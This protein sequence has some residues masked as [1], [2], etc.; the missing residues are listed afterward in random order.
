MKERKDEPRNAFSLLGTIDTCLDT[1]ILRE[2]VDS[3]AFCKATAQLI[4][5][6]H[7]PSLY[8]PL[9][10]QKKTSGT[11]VNKF[12][13]YISH[14]SNTSTI[15]LASP[16]PPYPVP[17]ISSLNNYFFHSSHVNS[18]APSLVLSCDE[19]KFWVEGKVVASWVGRER[20]ERKRIEVEFTSV[21]FTQKASIRSTSFI[22]RHDQLA[23]HIQSKFGQRNRT[24]KTKSKDKEET[25]PNTEF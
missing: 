24:T 11:I 7:I 21:I 9:F 14:H 23:L 18:F 6:C 10:C 2:L 8:D 19:V 13:S 4:F 17:R 5:D 16:F 12:F 20:N 1:N 25:F 15:P 22:W 3:G